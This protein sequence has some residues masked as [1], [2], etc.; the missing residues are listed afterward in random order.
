MFLKLT[1][2]HYITKFTEV[3]NDLFSIIWQEEGGG[4]KKDKKGK[5]KDKKEK[6][7]K[8]DKKGKKGK[9]GGDDDVRIDYFI[10]NFIKSK[11]WLYILNRYNE[12]L[13]PEKSALYIFSPLFSLFAIYK[14]PHISWY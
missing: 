8:K 4:K 11:G 14:K 7:G 12:E 5:K 13:K 2:K 6:K 10:E 1:H 9:K 3:N